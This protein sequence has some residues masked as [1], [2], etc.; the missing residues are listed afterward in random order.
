MKYQ[1]FGFENKD[2]D[3]SKP[4]DPNYSITW[5]GETFH[6][7]QQTYAQTGNMLDFREALWYPDYND[8]DS[9]HGP[10]KILG[11]YDYVSE[12][13]KL[14]MAVRDKEPL[15]DD[16]LNVLRR[17]A[18]DFVSNTTADLAVTPYS[19]PHKWHSRIFSDFVFSTWYIDAKFRSLSQSRYD[20]DTEN[21]PSA[22]GTKESPRAA[23]YSL[24][25]I[26]MAYAL[27]PLVQFFHDEEKAKVRI[28]DLQNV[29]RHPQEKR[30]LADWLAEEYDALY[31]WYDEDQLEIDENGY[32][33]D[34]PIRWEW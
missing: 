33:M 3:P 31:V 7:D 12:L 34:K 25:Y 29:M 16:L 8:P 22:P 17:T 6:F 24:E 15:T 26:D 19:G 14:R 9:E 10:Y 32:I 21:A 28:D 23:D 18:Y 20:S 11:D 30:E 27:I 2:Y 13:G 1:L 5:N 4:G